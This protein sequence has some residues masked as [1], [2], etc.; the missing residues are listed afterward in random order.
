VQPLYF[1]IEL[2]QQRDNPNQKRKHKNFCSVACDL[3]DV[4]LA[5]YRSLTIASRRVS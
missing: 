2:V 1:L 4:N 3:S 5:G